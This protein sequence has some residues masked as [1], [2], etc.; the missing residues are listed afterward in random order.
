MSAAAP[1]ARPVARRFNIGERKPVEIAILRN[2]E[3]RMRGPGQRRVLKTSVANVYYSALRSASLT[4]IRLRQR[5]AAV[6]AGGG[7]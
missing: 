7:R 2:G 4:D 1:A 3:I 6:L 5:R